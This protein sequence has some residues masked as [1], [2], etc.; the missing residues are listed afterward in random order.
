MAGHLF[1]KLGLQN[2]PDPDS[3]ISYRVLVDRP[4]K[5]FV[6][7]GNMPSLD[8]L[9]GILR[10]SVLVE[11]I[12]FRDI[13]KPLPS[14]KEYEETVE[15]N[16]KPT[17]AMEGK[18]TFKLFLTDGT[19]KT[20]VALEY[21]PCTQLNQL[22]VGAKL[23]LTDVNCVKGVLLLRDGNFKFI[24]APATPWPVPQFDYD[25]GGVV[26]SNE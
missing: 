21:E 6:G 9:T 24:G 20:F 22:R 2:I 25:A 19:D 14:A 18:R 13:G 3:N 4:L 15:D 11:V 10:G 8:D 7:A 26:S 12:S 16:D 1:T 17:F 23:L 5:D